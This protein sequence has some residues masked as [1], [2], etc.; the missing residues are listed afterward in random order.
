MDFID[1][2]LN[3]YCENHSTPES[4]LLYKITRET[5]L[6][7]L[8]PR[9]LSGHMQ[10]RFLSLISKLKQPR[11]ILEIGTYTGYS[12]LCLAE[13]LT[14]DGKLLTLDR[15]EELL[16]RVNGYF[17]ESK[18]HG[19]LEMKVGDASMIIPELD[20]KYDL[21]FIDAD[22]TNYCAYLRQVL[23]KLNVGA[24]VIADN[25]LWSGKVVKPLEEKDRDTPE[26]LKFNK[27]VNDTPELENVL[28]PIR[29]G[30]MVARRL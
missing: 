8:L 26:L 29:D 20:E 17:S 14:P 30:L 16:T 1:E 15:N 9:M 5:N 2:T 11:R 22:K 6:E 3:D 13:G 28:L 12:A 10:G 18:F 7:V 4:E 19:Q 27:L 24:L 23:P 21:V 25:V